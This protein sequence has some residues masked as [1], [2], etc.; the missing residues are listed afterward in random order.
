MKKWARANF[1]PSLPLNGDRRVTGSAEHIALSAEAAAEGIVLL[2]NEDGALPLPAGSKVALFG[3]AVYDYVKGGG[4]SGDVYTAYVRNFAEGFREAG[5]DVYEPLCDYYKD[6]VAKQYEAGAAPGMMAEPALEPAVIRDARAFTD[7]AVLCLSR[8]S[9]EGWD[10]SDV[11]FRGEPNPW[12]S[13]VTMPG[14]S[15]KIFPKGDF[16]LSE[17]EEALV[18]A[19]EEVFDKVIVLLNVGGVIDTKWIRDDARIRGALLPWQ[20]G[21]EGAVSAAKTVMGQYNPSGKLPDTFAG[22]LTDYPSTEG[23]H[24]SFWHVDYKEDI[25]V[26][27][28]YFETMKGAAE[29]V[30]YPF[31]YGLSYTTFETSCM[32][33]QRAEGGFAFRVKVENTGAAA[34]KEVAAIYLSAPAGKLGKPAR[35]LAAYAKTKL[36]QP[37][38]FQELELFVKDRDLASYDDLGKVREAAYVIEAGTYRFFLGGSVRDAREL[39]FTY[40]AAEDTVYEQLSHQLVPAGLTER[41]LADGSYEAL[42]TGPEKDINECIFPKMA[43][44]SEEGMVPRDRGRETYMLMHPYAEGVKPLE[45]VA[46][47]EMDLDAFV[48]QLDDEDL[49]EILGGQPNKGVSN[50]WG[51]GNNP[52]Y[53]IPNVSTADGPAGVRLGAECGISTTAWPCATAIASSWNQ[54][55]AAA[56]GKAGGEELKENNLQIWLAP[57]VNIHRNP[58][59][60]R[61][62]E[63][64]S[65]DPFLTGMTGAALV[66]GI[67]SNRVAA[68]VKHFAANNKET[69]RKNCDSRVSERALREIYLRGFEIIVK[70]ADPWTIMSSY[71]PINGQRASESRELLT[72]IL[73][74]EWGFGGMVTTDW[75]GRG[76]HYKEVLAGNDV[77]MANGYPDRIAKAMEMGALGREDLKKCAKRILEMI[78]KLD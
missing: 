67:Q 36:L 4:G 2:K 14:L 32:E 16:Y 42:P 38:E 30:V 68:S 17:A 78:L 52:R 15:A 53:G 9:G 72:G 3:K 24:E 18:A 54:D 40:T 10:R 49:R 65:E 29:K 76:E 61:N 63:Y 11:E 35:E 75:W 34:G 70:E 13:E 60:G 41:L 27:Y 51:M 25:Y 33:A 62:F 28:R 26:G 69:N 20:G 37:G 56:V 58:L 47:G 59:C 74:E 55:L 45:A 50:T 48:E 21:M 7:T 23:F 44:G 1:Q 5:A 71:N 43:P 77:K 64:Y 73:R 31:G 12:E 46:N 66:R 6:Y 22:E 39:E 8:F 19:I 57:A